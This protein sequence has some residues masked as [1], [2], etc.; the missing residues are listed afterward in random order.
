MLGCYLFWKIMTQ[1]NLKNTTKMRSSLKNEAYRLSRSKLELFLGCKRC[2][3]LAEKFGIKRPDGFPFTLN[4]AVD[5]LLKKEF[6]LYRSLKRPH[7]YMIQNNIKAIPFN[8]DQ[9]DTWRNNKK[10]IRYFLREINIDFGGAIDDIWIDLNTAELIIV[11]YKATSKQGEVTLDA[12]SQ[13]SY[14]RQ[15]EIY[16]WLFRKNGFDVS[17]T[18]YFVYCNGIKNAAFFNNQ[19]NFD[20]SVL[21]YVAK[22]NND[23]VEQEII[24][25]YNCLQSNQLPEFNQTCS[26]C[27]YVD[28]GLLYNNLINKKF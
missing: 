11:D 7:H 8:H 24:K 14:K 10:G 18:A 26:Y 22:D 4:K 1:I 20:V 21:S 28:K 6:D 5:E 3:F 15:I 9:L 19:L 27:S 16:Q 12:P 25:A 2:F 17:S 23:W 13:E